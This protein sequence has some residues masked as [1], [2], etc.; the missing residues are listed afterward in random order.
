MT[1]PIVL[2]AGGTGGHIFP[3]QA[4]AAE[5]M[6][7]GRKVALITDRR[8]T[9]YEDRFPG[10]DIFRIRAATFSGQGL[11]GKAR[12]AMEILAG[13]LQAKRILRQ[14]KAAVVVGFGGYPSLPTMLAAAW[15]KLPTIIHEQNAVLGRVNRLLAGRVGAI[16]ASFDPTTGIGAGSQDKV[17]VV[18]NPVRQAVSERRD[19][20]FHPPERGG[21]VRVLV[22]GGSQGA[23][24]FSEILPKA[25]SEL[26]DKLRQRLRL[27]QQCRAEDLPSVVAAYKEAGVDADLDTFIDDVPGALADCHLVISRAG[28][29]TVFE[30]TAVGR[31]AVFVPYPHAT[32]NHQDANARTVA[33]G[34]GARVVPQD[35]FT[36]TACRETLE[37]LAND[38]LTLTKMATASRNCGRPDAASALAGL[39]NR[40]VPEGAGS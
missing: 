13:V 26:P 21:Q 27:T 6:K 40:F 38:P 1:G 2:A 37:A 8:G 34:G 28:A 19:D 32:D 5:L 20:A 33:K 7:Q 10:V 36:V 22:L 39:V 25:V 11:S 4:L 35:K 30:V 29:S 17:T 3:A 24:V 18:G 16:A 14:L 31:P 9:G 23:T 12:G 15:A